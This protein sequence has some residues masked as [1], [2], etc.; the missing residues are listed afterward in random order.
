MYHPKYCEADPFGLTRFVLLVCG[1]AW[2]LA[3]AV[4][5]LRQRVRFGVRC[6]AAHNRLVVKHLERRNGMPSQRIEFPGS[7]GEPL[8][9]RLDTPETTPGAWAVF[10]HCFTCSKDSKAA[11]FIARA[12]AECVFH[13]I[14][15]VIPRATGHAFHGKLDSDSTANWTVGA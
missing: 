4:A 13:A 10:A 12:L 7:Q 11:A 3:L 14:W 2:T 9:G 5:F 8:A 1:G 6:R 15:T